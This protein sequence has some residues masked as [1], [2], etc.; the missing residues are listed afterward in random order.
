MNI[1]KQD[2]E[3]F[4]KET[5]F[6]KETIKKI[7]RALKKAEKIA[8][9]EKVIETK[10]FIVQEPQ[11]LFDDPSFIEYIRKVVKGKAVIHLE[12]IEFKRVFNIVCN[13]GKTIYI[14]RNTEIVTRYGR[15]HR[16]DYIMTANGVALQAQFICEGYEEEVI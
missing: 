3:E 9:I 7:K 2:M 5:M 4:D 8:K 12:S 16:I 14:N 6:D 10:K 1:N 13:D 15:S 11:Y